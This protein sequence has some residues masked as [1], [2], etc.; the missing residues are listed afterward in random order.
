LRPGAIANIEPDWIL[1]YTLTENNSHVRFL[2]HWNTHPICSGKQYEI[3]QPAIKLPDA[4]G[5]L[6]LVCAALPGRRKGLKGRQS[7]HSKPSS[8]SVLPVSGLFA[9]TSAV[10]LRRRCRNGSVVQGNR[11]SLCSSRPNTVERYCP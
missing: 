11:A 9:A 4:P 10:H 3:V 2:T 5:R 8:S 7:R 1:I 6:R